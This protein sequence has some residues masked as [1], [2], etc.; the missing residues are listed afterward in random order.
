LV[1]DALL[2]IA[3]RGVLAERGVP[4]TSEYSRMMTGDGGERITTQVDT[5]CAWKLLSG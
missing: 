4:C 1:V 5:G 3:R 2:P